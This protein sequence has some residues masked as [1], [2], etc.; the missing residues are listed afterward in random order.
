M[1]LCL[2]HLTV[3]AVLGLLAL[4]VGM[5]ATAVFWPRRSTRQK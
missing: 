5:I 4:G 3:P 1:F 2:F